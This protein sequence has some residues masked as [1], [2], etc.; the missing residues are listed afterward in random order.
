MD[1]RKSSSSQQP[2]AKPSK[3]G[4]SSGQAQ[5]AVKQQVAGAPCRLKILSMGSGGVGKS[6][7]IKRYCE[8]RFVSK[9]IATIGVDYGVKPVQL[10]GMDVRINFW[11]LS[12][13]AEF[14]EIRNEFYK[15]AQ[16]ILLVYDASDRA[17][18]DDL[19]T[20]LSEA[21]KY[22]ANPSDVPVALCANKVD[23]KRGV[24]EEEGRQFASTRGMHYFETSACTGGNVN[25]MFEF[26]FSSAL[27]KQ[28]PGQ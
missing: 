17:S 3:Q 11:D 2:P 13:H 27:K 8:E 10:D 22:G 9:Y 20:S 12:G 4:S 19:D 6:C 24:S 16:G 1:R 18:Y 5:Q 25:E 15:D 7:L 23:K 28:R 21:L 26:L 14:F